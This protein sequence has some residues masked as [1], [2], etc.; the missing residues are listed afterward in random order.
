VRV[1]RDRILDSC[2]KLLE[3]YGK[4][5][6]VLE[7]EYKNEVCL[8]CRQPIC[9]RNGVSRV[10]QYHCCSALYLFVYPE[11]GMPCR[12]FL[13]FGCRLV[14]GLALPSSSSLLPRANSKRRN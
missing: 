5:R 10:C 11:S 9:T 12:H 2:I 6:G 7:I 1:S 14:Q 8:C 13:R 3:N 4:E